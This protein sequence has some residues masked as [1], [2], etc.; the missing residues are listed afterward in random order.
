MSKTDTSGSVRVDLFEFEMSEIGQGKGAIKVIPF[1]ENKRDWLIYC[2]KFLAR[3]DVKGYKDNLLGKVIVAMDCEFSQI[4]NYP[5][6]VK[7]TSLRKLN[8]GAFIG[9]HLSITGNT[10]TCLIPFHIM[11][12]SKMKVLR[13]GDARAA[14][15][16]LASKFESK[17]APNGLLFQESFD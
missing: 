2:E 9:L 17:R 12:A 4:D 13:D 16:K 15:K 5:W 8:K 11:G 6:K 1:L 7:A 14:W 3:G 10:D